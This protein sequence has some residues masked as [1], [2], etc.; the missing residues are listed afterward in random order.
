MMV[1]FPIQKLHPVTLVVT[2]AVVISSILP[3]EAQAGGLDW[4]QLCE[5]FPQN[6]RCDSTDAL[7]SQQTSVVPQSERPEIIKIRAP[8]RNE[9]IQIRVSGNIV[10]PIH[11][12]R[13]VAIASRVLS[14]AA[15]IGSTFSP[16]P[17]GI[18][19]FHNWNEQRTTQVIFQPDHCPHRPNYDPNQRDKPIEQP[20]VL[21]GSQVEETKFS[22]T[23][24]PGSRDVESGRSSRCQLIGT[25]FISLP[26][27]VD[28]SQGRFTIYY[29]EGDWLR[30]VT[31]RVPEQQRR[32]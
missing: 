5:Q 3:G 17:L 13:K 32:K 21:P 18:P 12:T 26:P 23:Q 4:K 27:D 28:I 7:T 31:F 30:S 14:T 24:F 16:V 19:R 25:G 2:M 29:A 9:R 1:V 10:K 15:N 22:E 6:A 11:A 8:S 20:P